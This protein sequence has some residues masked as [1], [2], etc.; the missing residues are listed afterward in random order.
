MPPPGM[1][2]ESLLGVFADQLLRSSFACAFQIIA[3]LF[4]YQCFKEGF[5]YQIRGDRTCLFNACRRG[6][7]ICPWVVHA[8]LVLASCILGQVEI[9]L[10]STS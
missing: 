5:A 6:W 2:G 9:F 10:V 1:G 3:K 7:S 8:M 4:A